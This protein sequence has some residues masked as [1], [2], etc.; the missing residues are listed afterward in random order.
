MRTSNGRVPPY[1]SRSTCWPST[2]WAGSCGGKRRGRSQRE[3]WRAP[4]RT[5]RTGVA[6][7][8]VGACAVVVESTPAS[9]RARSEASVVH[10]GR[11]A[12]S[13]REIGA[14]GG[15][16][17]GGRRGR[18]GCV[19]RCCWASASW[20]P[21]RPGEASSPTKEVR[22]RRRSESGRPSTDP[23]SGRPGREVCQPAWKCS[24]TGA[25]AARPSST[26]LALQLRLRR[27]RCHHERLKD[28]QQQGRVYSR[29]A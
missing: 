8:R 2:T 15:G 25:L 23:P 21:D 10:I 4:A 22:A 11:R 1:H 12:G 27:A 18:E 28:R 26:A 3:P 7:V 5:V 9:E 19:L 13:L 24:S 6:T 20:A 14:D 29:V 17:S 16:G